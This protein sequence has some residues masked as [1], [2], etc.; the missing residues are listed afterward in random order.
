MKLA[1][2]SFGV[3]INAMSSTW[4]NYSTLINAGI[5]PAAHIEGVVPLI[6][7]GSLTPTTL[8]ITVQQTAL[9]PSTPLAQLVPQAEL[10]GTSTDA[11]VVSRN[12]PP[13]PAKVAEKIW[14]K[15][16]IEMELLLPTRLGVPEPTLGDLVAGERKQQ[17]EKKTISRAQE[18]VVCFNTYVAIVTTREPDRVKDLLA[19]ASLIVKASMDYEGDAWLH[20]DRFFRRQAAAEPGRYPHWGEID[21]SIW[22][23]Q[24]GR[25]VAR[26]S[27]PDCGSYNH[28]T[29]SMG[30]GSKQ[31]SSSRFGRARSRPYQK[32]RHQPICQRWN[33][34]DYCSPSFCSYQHVCLECY[35]DHQARNCPRKTSGGGNRPAGE[36]K[37]DRKKEGHNFRS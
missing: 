7:Q 4:V 28:T 18:W 14:K 17:K 25:A 6:T 9:S 15:E 29:C 11:V 31:H 32:S 37:E 24:F 26:P 20:Y 8:P 22:T 3:I 5:P 19:Y 23:Q 16:F 2:F 33:R 13:V 21:P 36:K 35:K 27:C 30:E 34:G 12:L 1:C 10:V